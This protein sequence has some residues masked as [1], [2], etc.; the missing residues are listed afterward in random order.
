MPLSDKSVMFH[1]LAKSLFK[2]SML[3]CFMLLLQAEVGQVYELVI[4][5]ASGLYRYRF[6]D[7]IKVV[8]HHNTCPVIEFHYR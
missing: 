1:V 7:V 3:H 4:T 8:G 2:V 6:G 5:N